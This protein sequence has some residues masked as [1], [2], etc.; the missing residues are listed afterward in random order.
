VS[1]QSFFSNIFGGY[2]GSNPYDNPMW[3]G[4]SGTAGG[5]TGWDSWNSGGWAGGWND[6]WGGGGIYDP[7]GAGYGGGQYSNFY[8]GN[9]PGQTSGQGNGTGAKPVSTWADVL[10]SIFTGGGG[11]GGGLG[12][13]GTPGIN[14]NASTP[15][16]GGGANSAGGG[17]AAAAANAAK[18]TLPGALAIINSLLGTAGSL[19]NLFGDVYNGINNQQALDWLRGAY[20]NNLNFGRGEYDAWKNNYAGV[21]GDL[22]DQA[23]Q[24]LNAFGGAAQRGIDPYMAAA[25]GLSGQVPGLME[26]Y[27]GAFSNPETAGASGSLQD[28]ISQAL[29]ISNNG[30]WTNQGNQLFEQGQQFATGQNDPMRAFSNIG[31]YLLNSGGGTD[32]NRGLQDRGLD[33]VNSGGMTDI[34]QSVLSGARGIQGQGGATD[35]TKTGIAQALGMLMNGGTTSGTSALDAAGQSALAGNLGVAG[36]TNTGAQGELAALAGLNRGGATATSQALQQKALEILKTNPTMSLEDAVS[37]A[38]DAAATAAAQQG[39]SVRARA[40]ARGGGPGAIVASGS[41]NQGMADFADQALRAES[42]AGNDARAKQQGVLMD[43]LKSGASMGA[44]SGDLERGTLGTYA[45]LLKGLEGVAA[46]RFSTGGD[47][48]G[49]GTALATDRANTGFS[50]LGNLGNLE[51]NRLLEALKLQTGAQGAATSNAGTLGQLGLGGASDMTNRLNTGSNM[52]QN[53]LSSAIAGTGLSG[54]AN[55]DAMQYGLGA[56]NMGVNAAN[57]LGGLG[58]NA[59]QLGQQRFSN[60]FGALNSGVTQ[61]GNAVNNALTG[62]QNIGI[63]PLIQLASQSGNILS[64]FG[65]NTSGLPGMPGTPNTWAGLGGGK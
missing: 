52:L 17:G 15:T 10:S 42:A 61:Q 1:L 54:R 50:G 24:G 18:A 22:R 6:G 28:L 47:L 62:W 39:E 57:N 32:F 5:G 14:P 60:I 29:G 25:F 27:G 51:T 33:A 64:T 49:K 11:F 21:A 8:P 43:Y 20:V 44:A 9:W 31:Q 4:W 59:G 63:N 16:F 53:W 37:A 3:D 13:G 12:P 58:I 23:N 48:L 2:G 34:L 30:G 45:D 40:L 65:N 26:Q 56:G 35:Y 46:S 7:F 41:Q 38:R 55:A 19:G 36:L